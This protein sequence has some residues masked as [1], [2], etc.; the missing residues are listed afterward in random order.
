MNEEHISLGINPVNMKP[1]HVMIAD[2]SSVD[3][4][5]VRR[6]LLSEKFEIQHESADG[7]DLL[8][9]LESSN[10]KPE[11]LCLDLQLPKKNGLQIIKEVKEKYPHIK[12]IV[13]SAITDKKVLGVLQSL[14]VHTFVMKPYSRIQLID[15]IST[16]LGRNE[17]QSTQVKN[18]NLGDMNI[19]PLPAVAMKVMSFDST[20]PTGGSEEL[21]KIIGPDKAIT[22]DIMKIANSAYY[23]RA[24]SIQTLKDAITLLGMKTVKNLVILQ[25]S[26]KYTKD[27]KDPIYQKV[28]QELPIL[29]SLIAFDL[30]TPL[31][32]KKLR[33]EVFIASLLRKIGM[34][35]LALNNTSSYKAILESSNTDP[36]SILELEMNA[37]STNHLLIGIKVFKLWNMPV[38]LQE[39]V[40]NQFFRPDEVLKVSD[41]DRIC[42]LSYFLAK[43]MLGFNLKVIEQDVE[44]VLYDTYHFTNEMKEAFGADYYDMIKDHPFFEMLV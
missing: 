34:T 9:Y 17:S 25:A 30:T 33:E 32:L 14:K 5:L 19:P 36:R 42:R 21:E 20:N 15:K 13:I 24:G 43:K 31:N 26:K 23:G 10:I 1:I 37:Y 18:T 39:V 44:F 28:L 38:Q 29:S 40:A 3:R 27:L 35:I 16:L 6:F 12:I 41:I 8:Y 7:D 11:L 2:D 4:A 22:A